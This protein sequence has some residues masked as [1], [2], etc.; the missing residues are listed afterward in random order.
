MKP[1]LKATVAIGC[2]IAFAGTPALGQ[3]TSSGGAG[4]PANQTICDYYTQAVF[5]NIT[6][7]NELTLL[8]LLVNTVVIG[9][10]SPAA[11]QSVLVPGILSSSGGLA[12]YFTGADKTTNRNNVPT[13]VNFLDGGGAA[14]LLNNTPAMDTKSNQYILISHLYTGFGA[15]LGCSVQASGAAFP[16]YEGVT[17]MFEVHKFM[18]LNKTEMDFFI[19]QV[20]LAA[21]SFGVADSDITVVG[22]L[23]NSAFNQKCLP[24][25]PLVPGAPNE[26]QSICTDDSCPTA[27]NASCAAYAAALPGGSST[28]GASTRTA[29]PSASASATASVTAGASGSTPT[30]TK[31]GAAGM[32]KVGA[33]AFVP[34]VAVVL[35]AMMM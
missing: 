2:L 34:A 3:S 29:G 5:G 9:N 28:S 32:L 16:T 26:L 33:G 23:L 12:K 27:P 10:Y 30:G 31:P 21:Q 13:A 1:T 11:N 19:T 25:A 7:E 4:R 20:A 24:A 14:P 15:L 17:S 6:A 18:R 22:G 35:A 8:T